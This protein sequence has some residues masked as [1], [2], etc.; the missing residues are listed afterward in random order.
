M[1]DSWAPTGRLRWIERVS[2]LTN[3]IM[4]VLQQQWACQL[5]H[6]PTE[7]RDVPVEEET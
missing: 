3:V 5:I 6:C 1:S 7:W 2:P 4:R